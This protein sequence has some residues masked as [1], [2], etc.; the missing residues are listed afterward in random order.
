MHHTCIVHAAGWL[1][2]PLLKGG[3]AV[4]KNMQSWRNES[5]AEGCLK[6]SQYLL[7]IEFFQNLSKI[8][9]W[10]AGQKQHPSSTLN[11][12]RPS[13][14]SS[15]QRRTI[16]YEKYKQYIMISVF[17]V[18]QRKQWPDVLF[19]INIENKILSWENSFVLFVHASF[20]N[21]NWSFCVTP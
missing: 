21:Y 19:K 15:L 14:G 20:Y 9:E 4:L 11:Q 10:I 6:Q 5:Q 16:I 13:L 3:I 2:V 17:Y 12:Q 7:M 18:G 8:I 1:T